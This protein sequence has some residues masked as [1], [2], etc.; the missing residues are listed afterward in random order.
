[1]AEGTAGSEVAVKKV[2]PLVGFARSGVL[3]VGDGKGVDDVDAATAGGCC[4]WASVCE[5]WVAS[6]RRINEENV[7]G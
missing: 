2:S 4:N 6:S 3:S 5:G 7:V 1:M